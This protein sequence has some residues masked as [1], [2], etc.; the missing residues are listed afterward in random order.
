MMPTEL[1]FIY[2]NTDVFINYNQD[3]QKNRHVQNQTDEGGAGKIVW[4]KNQ[5]GAQESTIYMTCLYAH[6]KHT[7]S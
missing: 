2:L 4:K 7:E 5:K 1:N 6:H 3:R